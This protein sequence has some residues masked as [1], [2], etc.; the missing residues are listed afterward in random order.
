M[1]VQWSTWRSPQSSVVF[2]H[3]M[4][5][6]LGMQA[7][8]SASHNRFNPHR[9]V[10]CAPVTGE[11]RGMTKAT[12]DIDASLRNAIKD[13]SFLLCVFFLNLM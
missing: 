11:Q 7:S 2:D 3:T 8:W 9:P 5:G 4:C 10:I 6:P 1:D 12:T 13:V